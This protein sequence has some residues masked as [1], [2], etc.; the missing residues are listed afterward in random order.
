MRTLVGVVPV[1]IF[2]VLAT[3][4][5]FHAGLQPDD[6][7]FVALR[8]AE[9]FRS[10]AGLVFNPGERRDLIDSPLWVAQLSML[11]LSVRAPLLVQLYGLV[12]GVLVLLLLLGSPR[13][14]RG[15]SRGR[16]RSVRVAR[17]RGGQRAFGGAAPGAALPD[18]ARSARARR[19]TP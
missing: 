3:I 14:R 17:H 5:C 4:Q 2:L 19:R 7:G 6:S 9:N 1:L 8:V 16:R 15:A 10:G 18:L 13:S 11:T 12:L